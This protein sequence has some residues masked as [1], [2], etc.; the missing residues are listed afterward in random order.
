MRTA[1]A[2]LIQFPF[3]AVGLFV[4]VAAYSQLGQERWFAGLALGLLALLILYAGIVTRDS[5]RDGGPT[6]E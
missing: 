6:R 5:L 3:M 1:A 2:F 4:G